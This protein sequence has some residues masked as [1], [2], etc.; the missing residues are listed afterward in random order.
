MTAGK[1]FVRA[2]AR[3]RLMTVKYILWLMRGVRPSGRP[4]GCAGEFQ[5]ADTS[6]GAAKELP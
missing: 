5:A 1:V 3:T 4:M 6:E 2:T